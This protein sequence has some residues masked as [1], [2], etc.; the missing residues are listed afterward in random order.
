M[1]HVDGEITGKAGGPILLVRES[2][3]RVADALAPEPATRI[4]VHEAFQAWDRE[5]LVWGGIPSLLFSPQTPDSEFDSC[6]L[7]LLES[8]EPGDPFV[9]GIGDTIP[10]EADF[11]RLLRFSQLYR[12]Y[13][14]FGEA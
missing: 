7:S 5:M 2:G 11:D 14:S 6:V 4:S 9:L 8:I 3:F 10:I 12:A 1:A 13:C